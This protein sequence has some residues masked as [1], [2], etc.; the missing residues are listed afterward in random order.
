MEIDE[1]IRVLAEIEESEVD[2]N[3]QLDYSH[4]D[5]VV[6]EKFEN[7]FLVGQFFNEID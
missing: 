6:I 1:I 3:Q 5:I 2:D 7:S 4:D